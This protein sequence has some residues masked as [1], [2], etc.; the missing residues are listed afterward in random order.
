MVDE[1]LKS[2]YDFAMKF[3]VGIILI[4]VV[5]QWIEL[6]CFR[7]TDY[8]VFHKKLQ[9]NHEICFL[10]DLHG[11]TYSGRLIEKIR[12]L[13]PDVIVIG[14]DVVSKKE[15][16]Q[17]TSMLNFLEELTFIA[18]VYYCFGNHETTIHELL[19]K[20]SNLYE[21]KWVSYMD[22]VQA[23]GIT[24]VRNQ[25]IKL[26]DDINLTALELPYQYFEKK[27]IPKLTMDVMNKLLGKEKLDNTNFEILV[28]HHPLF[29][30]NYLEL[31][32]DLILSG[33]THGGLIRF[34]VIGSIISTE[35]QWNPEFDGGKYELENKDG[36]K[37][38]LIVSKGLGTHTFHI[39]VF[40]RAEIIMIHLKQEK[41][42]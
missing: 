27:D 9:E 13:N 28:A 41:E 25:E 15:P 39:R 6:K 14:G 11:F 1:S 19:S 21:E 40:D 20:E 29:A 16:E 32:P 42:K 33:H 7:V 8:T 30:R 36:K 10:S 23:M 34:P 35:F 24:I 26:F 31:E 18:K 3:L 22:K 17:M 2:R 5:L 38:N 37:C 4:Y 12:K